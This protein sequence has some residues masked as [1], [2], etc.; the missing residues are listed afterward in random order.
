MGIVGQNF[1]D[2]V[3]DQVNARQKFL[4]TDDKTDK[5][6]EAQNVNS[7][8]RLASSVDIGIPPDLPE[9][10]LKDYQKRI[11]YYKQKFQLEGTND[12]ELARQ[13]VLTGGTSFIKE[14]A[15]GNISLA[16]HEGINRFPGY[17]LTSPLGA[18]GF[19]GNEF[20]YR[21]MPGIQSAKTSYYNNGA[22]QRADIELICFSAEQLDLLEVLYLRP[23]YTILLEWGHERYVDNTGQIRTVI[24]HGGITTALTGFFAGVSKEELQASIEQERVKRSYNY[25]AIHAMITNFSWTLNTDA[26]YKITLKVITLGAVIE[27]LK[28][29][30][31]STATTLP[32]PET[33]N[34][35]ETAPAVEEAPIPTN[36][37]LQT[38]LA[39]RF[40]ESPLLYNLTTIVDELQFGVTFANNTFQQHPNIV[41]NVLSSDDTWSRT[42]INLIL[43]DN[44][45]NFD[46]T[47]C[48]SYGS[49]TSIPVASRDSKPNKVVGTGDLDYTAFISFDT[50]LSIVQAV[51][52]IYEKEGKPYVRTEIALQDCIPMLHF[53]G[54]FSADPTVCI[55]PFNSVISSEVLPDGKLQLVELEENFL[56]GKPFAQSYPGLDIQKRQTAAPTNYVTAMN[57]VVNTAARQGGFNNGTKVLFPTG[58]LEVDPFVGYLNSVL[59]NI[60]YIIQ[61]IDQKTDENGDVSFIDFFQELLSGINDAL[62]GINNFKVKEDAKTHTVRIYDEACHGYLRQKATTE[63]KSYGVEIGKASTIIKGLSLTT[64]LSNEMASMIAIGAQANGNQVGENATAFSEFNAGLYD[65]VNPTKVIGNTTNASQKSPFEKFQDNCAAILGYVQALYPLRTLEGSPELYIEDYRWGFN[66]NINNITTLKKLNKD[67]S[68]FAIGYFTNQDVQLES[69][70]IIPFKLSVT[71]PGLA[72][73]TIYEKFAMDTILLPASYDNKVDY[74]IVGVTHDIANN[75]WDTTYE[76]YTVPVPFGVRAGLPRKAGG[77]KSILPWLG[78]NISAALPAT[79][80]ATVGDIIVGIGVPVTSPAERELALWKYGTVQ[81][82][83]PAALPIL[84]RYTRRTPGIAAINYADD[85]APWSAVYVSYIM[86][87][88]DRFFPVSTAHKNYMLAAPTAGYETITLSLAKFYNKRIQLQVGDI[89]VQDRRDVNGNPV[90]Y[91]GDI[92]YKIQGNTVFLTGGNLGNTAVSFQRTVPNAILAPDGSINS[93]SG[94]PYAYIVKKMRQV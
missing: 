57:G 63:F 51:S 43:A 49:I 60:E 90:G 66:L 40:L 20:G 3:R 37:T 19:G 2:G 1:K 93:Y 56:L 9:S 27:S 75:K 39:G 88:S 55:I 72:G 38:R 59:V 85:T 4:S 69:P 46:K 34:T 5:V 73:G 30:S 71:I 45:G 31:N 83:D 32:T 21:P 74:L 91:H 28:I 47:F 50:L 13:V 10:R 68:K 24:E 22:L 26:T 53:P 29:S 6:I 33:V 89:L 76:A 16:N 14:D 44:K 77:P 94:T 41:Q 18:Y 87:D 48:P 84:E 25:D 54:R 78:G 52:T 70:F 62:G 65:R 35:Q 23:G 61:I 58:S 7:W 80:P 15:S 67:Y 64:Q 82:S 17:N 79:L 11:D 12:S 8:L 42:D 36:S 92:I 86:S 81:E